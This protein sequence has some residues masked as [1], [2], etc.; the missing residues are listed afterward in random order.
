MFEVYVRLIEVCAAV[1]ASACWGVAAVVGRQLVR[2]GE[3]A[4]MISRFRYAS[5][6]AVRAMTLTALA[7][8]AN[9]AAALYRV[10]E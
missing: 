9:A 1:A 6:W 5:R 10:I 8:F 4:V 7:A 3:A 2:G